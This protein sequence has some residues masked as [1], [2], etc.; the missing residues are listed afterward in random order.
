MQINEHNARD[1]A[2]SN[3][4]TKILAINTA[5]RKLL[6]ISNVIHLISFNAQIA[7]A[8]AGENGKSL[9]VLTQEINELAP[10]VA[11]HIE[12]I[13]SKINDIARYNAN[14]M[15]KARQQEVFKR[16]ETILRR[17]GRSI[18]QAAH[19]SEALSQEAQD[20][21][22][23]LAKQMRAIRPALK[24]IEDQAKATE[25]IG[26]LLRIEVAREQDAAMDSR[27]FMAMAEQ[28]TSSCVQMKEITEQCEAVLTEALSL[29]NGP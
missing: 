19:R 14:C 10:A 27:A 24:A 23:I 11:E 15:N 20:S 16:T 13:T 17:E 8:H 12:E 25:M 26:S 2:I 29:A 9:G 22:Q 7:S 1:R 6:P 3:I 5:S 21:F 28:M 4:F 18:D